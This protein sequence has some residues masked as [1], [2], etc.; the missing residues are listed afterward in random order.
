[1]CRESEVPVHKV[2]SIF[3]PARYD[4]P[5]KVIL[6]GERQS[7]IF[8]IV[9]VSHVLLQIRCGRNWVEFTPSLVNGTCFSQ[10]KFELRVCFSTLPIL[11]DDST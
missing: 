6:E 4:I 10:I 8:V 5:D 3:E 7:Y 11:Q 1:M 2:G 9:E